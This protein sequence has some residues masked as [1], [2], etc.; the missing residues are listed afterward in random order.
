MC[1]IVQ[2]VEFIPDT[3]LFTLKCLV[4][5]QA[6]KIGVLCYHHPTPMHDMVFITKLFFFSSAAKDS[7]IATVRIRYFH[8]PVD[9]AVKN[10]LKKV[11]CPHFLNIS[12]DKLSLLH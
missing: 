3:F 5:L 4:R 8:L 9:A 7:I 2:S 10:L 12:L 6:Y 1:Y 11:V